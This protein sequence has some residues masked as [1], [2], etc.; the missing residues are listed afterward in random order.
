MIADP[1]PDYSIAKTYTLLVEGND[2]RLEKDGQLICRIPDL[3][4]MFECGHVCNFKYEDNKCCQCTSIVVELPCAL[5]LAIPDLPSQIQP[6][7]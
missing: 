2:L 5:C 7:D 6:N 3:E 4:S 1:L